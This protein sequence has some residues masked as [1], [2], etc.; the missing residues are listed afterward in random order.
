MT[1]KLIPQVEI[2]GVWGYRAKYEFSNGYTAS[3]VWE[4]GTIPTDSPPYWKWGRKRSKTSLYSVAVMRNGR[5]DYSTPITESPLLAEAGV[6]GGLSWAGAMR[7]VRRIAA[8]K[9]QPKLPLVKDLRELF[10]SL[11]RQIADE[12][13]PEEGGPPGF[14]VTIGCDTETG[15]WSWQ[16]GDNSYTGGAYGYP[17]WAVVWLTRR[18]DSTGLARDVR[19]QLE[20]LWYSSR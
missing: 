5:I 19:D 4:R 14:D 16:T 10:V 3:V 2:W 1:T 12:Y 8:L 17:D 18:S 15:A 11:K 13:I 7:V 9:V 20:E 6:V